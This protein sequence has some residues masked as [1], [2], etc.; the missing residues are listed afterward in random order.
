MPT[1]I[2]GKIGVVDGDVDPR[3]ESGVDI[4]DS[5]GGQEQNS[6]VIFLVSLLCQHVTQ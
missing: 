1:G 5:V 6:L 4:A 2:N 3:V